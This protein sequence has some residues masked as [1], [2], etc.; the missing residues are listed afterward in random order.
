MKEASG[1]LNLTVI[2]IIA[3]AAVAGLFYAFIWPNIEM[4]IKNNTCK[5]YGDGWTAVTTDG[6]AKEGVVDASGEQTKYACCPKG[7]SRYDNSKCVGI[8]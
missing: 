1:E 2:T 6:T 8:Q 3:I 5:S 7:T 4:S